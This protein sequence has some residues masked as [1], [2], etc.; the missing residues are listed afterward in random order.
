MSTI[1]TGST[2]T[3]ASGTTYISGT[4]G[5]DSSS[6]IAAAVEA[7]MQPAYRLDV[8]I[9]EMEAEAAAYREMHTL[10]ADLETA[11]AALSGGADDAAFDT[12]A[13][14]LTA[15]GLD[16]PQHYLSATVTDGAGAG[17][18]DITVDQ[19]AQGMQVASAEHA[20][21][22]VLGQNGSF[23]LAADG[24]T[25]T[26]IAVTADMTVSDIADA[27]NAASG[28]TGVAATVIRTSDGGQTLTLSTVDTGVSFSAASVSGDDVLQALGI[29]APGGAFANLLQAAQEAVLTVDG[30]TV[31]SAGNDIEDLVP[32]VSINLYGAT[33][34]QTITLD[35]GQD[36]GAV[37]TAVDGFVDAFNAYRT[38]ALNQQATADGEG[39]SDGAT[40]FGETLLKS[41][42]AALYDAMET[43]VDVAGISYTAADFG[44]TYGAGN[45]LTIDEAILEEALLQR[46]EVVE[47][48]FAS[49]AVAS[50]PDLGVGT[51]SGTL[52]GGNYT[53]DITTDL[54]TGALL[55]ASI[56]GEAMTVSGSSIVGPDGTAYEG[57]RLVYTGTQ[58]ASIVLTVSQGLA[59]RMVATLDGYTDDNDGQVTAKIERLTAGIDDK[60]D[61][62]NTIAQSTA[63]YE[64]H[65]IETYARLEQEIARSEIAL[66]RLEQ[67]LGTDD[68]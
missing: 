32:G 11:A 56:E 65:L 34:G 35:V 52:A 22:A 61:R 58:S 23:V 13:A 44:L 16:D 42:N 41:A 67:L 51:L 33:A 38:F 19:L 2:A 28:D 4:S 1:V 39:A 6:L 64:A 68:D 46:P 29:T 54:D 27:I 25:G 12:Y 49:N 17:L 20:V 5:F 24:Y 26:E 21:D 18:Y 10:M 66:R 14:Y 3:G 40:L 30:V 55:S 47:A 53:V 63:G 36:L 45:L 43:G 62:R 48:F 8:Q 57:L 9:A 59:D 15:P 7:K 50:S 60:Q 31:T 37:R